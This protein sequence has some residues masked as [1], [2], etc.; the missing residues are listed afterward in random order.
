[1][2]ALI[3][4]EDPNRTIVKFSEDYSI[5]QSLFEQGV[6]LTIDVFCSKIIQ[7]A[8][9]ATL[10]GGTPSPRY[11]IKPARE[12][13]SDIKLNITAKELKGCRLTFVSSITKI[14]VEGILLTDDELNNDILLTVK[15]LLKAGEDIIADFDVKG[16]YPRQ[17][18]ESFRTTLKFKS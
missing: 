16:K 18:I 14:D 12:L 1:M 4:A 2:E 11:L 5:K 13:I 15:Y 17:V 8:H 7:P 3:I 10:Y 9:S 6:S